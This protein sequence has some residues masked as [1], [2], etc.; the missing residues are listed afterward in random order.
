MKRGKIIIWGSG[1][2]AKVILDAVR[3]DNRY[4]PFG[5]IDDI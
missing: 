5:F 3:E 1:G 2:H 4:T